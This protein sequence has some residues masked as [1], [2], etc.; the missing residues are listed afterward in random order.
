MEG[1]LHQR[2]CFREGRFWKPDS[3]MDFACTL[4]LH[5]GCVGGWWLLL[6]QTPKTSPPR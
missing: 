6:L 4:W 2:L 1:S 3:S 5:S